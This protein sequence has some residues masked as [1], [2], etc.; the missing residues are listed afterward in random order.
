MP[1]GASGK[2]MGCPGR[3]ARPG[4]VTS[5]RE[6]EREMRADPGGS[7]RFGGRGNTKGR[8][9]A[10]GPGADSGVR[11]TLLRDGLGAEERAGGPLACPSELDWMET[12]VAPDFEAGFGAR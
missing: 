11:P 2:A 3:R 9:P 12:G 5:N 8:C 6:T 10:G 7:A 4:R 1:S